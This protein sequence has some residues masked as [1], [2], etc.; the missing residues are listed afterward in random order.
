MDGSLISTPFTFF[1]PTQ[2]RFGAGKLQELHT[3]ASGLGSRVLL[4]TRPRQENINSL[5]KRAFCLKSFQL[6]ELW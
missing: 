2:I 1:V 4:V 6:L 3:I 5:I